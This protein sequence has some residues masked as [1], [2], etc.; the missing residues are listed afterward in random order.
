MARRKIIQWLAALGC[1]AYVPGFSRGG[2]YKGGLKAICVPGLN[3][4]SCP[5]AV[6]SCPLGALQAVIGASRY[7]FSYYAAGLLLAF[8]L[9]FGR[10]IC[11]FLCPFGLLQE[12]LR[13][14]PFFRPGNGALAPSRRF[15][16][17]AKFARLFKYL[18]YILLVV[19]VLA[20]PFLTKGDTGVG[21]PAFCKYICP[22]GTLEAGVPLLAANAPMRETLGWLFT[23]KAS[24]ALFTVIGC[25]IT[26][27]FF[28]KFLCP[29][30]AFYGLFNRIAL[31]QIHLD[32]D[33][34]VRCGR[35]AQICQMAVDPSL[36]PNCAE[37]VRCGDCVKTC[38]TSALSA[39]F[40]GKDAG[41]AKNAISQL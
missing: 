24:I 9:I 16:G 30:G 28:C 4:Y 10:V 12:L 29:L 26:Y 34:C 23:L 11:G 7:S 31:Y 40:R 19:F 21:Q 36:D 33:R 32:K 35:C 6:A 39:G 22:A 5:G 13:K 14:I 3:C 25:V 38:P 18:K 1:N 37:C 17:F 15:A 2:I 41:C 20:L 8:G 27:R